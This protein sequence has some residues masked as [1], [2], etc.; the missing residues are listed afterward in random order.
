VRFG[1]RK[2]VM[3]ISEAELTAM[4]AR[5]DEMH[6]AALPEM[7]EAVSAWSG[8]LRDGLRQAGTHQPSRRGFLLGSGVA[9]GGVALAACGGTDSA[10]P[11]TTTTVAGKAPS[12]SDPTDAQ[13]AMLATALENTAVLTYATALKAARSGKLGDVPPSVATFV[14][15]VQQQHQDHADAWNAALPSGNKVGKQIDTTLM[16]NVVGPALAN[17]K[18]IAGVAALALVLEN[19]AAATYQQSL[20]QLTDASQLQLPA[21]IQPVEMQHASILMFLLG[22]Y[23]VPDSFSTTDAARPV[24]DHI[25]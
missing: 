25:G 7:H 10:K 5:L 20:Q 8:K 22:R 19:A 14:T 9:L 17:V 15:T 18:D 1:R 21:S 13:V 4:T 3:H 16:D 23:P 11:P 24:T 6:R 12:K 2:D